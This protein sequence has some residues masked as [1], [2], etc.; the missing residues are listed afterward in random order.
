VKLPLERGWIPPDGRLQIIQRKTGG[1]H[2]AQ[3]R[4]STIAAIDA[5]FPP[6]RRRCWPLYCCLREWRRAAAE[7]VRSAGLSGSI[8][9]LRHSSG[10]AAEVAH[11]GRGHEHLGNGRAVFERHYLDPLAVM[12]DPPLPPE[13]PG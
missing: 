10:T 6:A 1:R 8:G 13:L 7:L 3:L 12:S 9:R 5:T 4:P 11:P 2:V